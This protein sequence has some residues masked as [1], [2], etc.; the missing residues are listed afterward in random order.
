MSKL[1]KL[2]SKRKHKSGKRI[3]HSICGD[4]DWKRLMTPSFTHEDLDKLYRI[5]PEVLPKVIVIGTPNNSE[6]GLLLKMYKKMAKDGVCIV[7]RR[8]I[9]TESS[10]LKADFIIHDDV[11]K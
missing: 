7:E 6:D 1:P 8:F 4:I 11:L 9:D 2:K 3:K 5:K 10:G